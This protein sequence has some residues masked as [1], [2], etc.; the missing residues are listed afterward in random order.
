MED[1]I[2]AFKQGAQR[3]QFGDALLMNRE[4]RL[5]GQVIEIR[6]VSGEEIIDD[7]NLMT[8]AQQAFRNMRA[9]EACP[10][11]DYRFHVSSP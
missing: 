3:L 10:A 9:D 6:P 1:G 8:L 4:F 5:G 2:D 7:V 11:R